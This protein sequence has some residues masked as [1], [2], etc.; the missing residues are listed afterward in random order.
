MRNHTKI[1][2]CKVIKSII[3]IDPPFVEVH[4]AAQQT[5]ALGEGARCQRP[6]IM[7]CRRGWMNTTQEDKMHS[8]PLLA[9]R[10][11]GKDERFRIEPL[12]D[13]SA[14]QQN[15]VIGRDAE[16]CS[17]SS[18]P[19]RC[20]WLRNSKR[21]DRQNVFER[22]AGTR[23]ESKR[24]DPVEQHERAKPEIGLPLRCADE[25]IRVQNLVDEQHGRLLVERPSLRNVRPCRGLQ[26]LERQRAVQVC[27]KGSSS[28]PQVGPAHEHVA[29]NH[30]DVR[31]GSRVAH[32][33]IAR[34]DELN[35]R[36]ASE[37]AR[38]ARDERCSEARRQG[39]TQFQGADRR[40]RHLSADDIR[41]DD[42]Y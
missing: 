8:A 19:R 27:D 42:G 31:S 5:K 18:L 20:P 24:I 10:V 2:I 17:K 4:V 26:Q 3:V 1:S 13:A 41:T 28:P 33:V 32:R 37:V 25:M 23:R 15:Q 21:D 38:T 12:V 39:A 29:L 40:A 35:P 22:T 16:T 14:P 34:L 7:R 6:S 9:E 36:A 30:D 11:H